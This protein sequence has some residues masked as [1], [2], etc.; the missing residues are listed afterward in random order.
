[1]LAED[2]RIRAERLVAL[3]RDKRLT[4]ASAESCTGGLLAGVVT[5]VPGASDIFDRGFVTY[6]NAAKVECLG[7]SPELLERFGAVSPEVAA[8]MA[9][10]ALNH[11]RADI[12]MSITGIAGPGGGS[13][14]KPVGLVH[15]GLARRSEAVTTVEQRFGDIGRDSVRA[16]ALRVALELL[17]EAAG[18]PAAG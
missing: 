17:F 6:S 16:A 15:F 5:S 14:Q 1:M 11:S 13:A 4:L 2:L 3:Y 18:R 9:E 12:A 8:A 10:G 7:V